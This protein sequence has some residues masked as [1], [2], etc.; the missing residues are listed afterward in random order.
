MAELAQGH[1]DR[2]K[3]RYG[4]QAIPLVLVLDQA[5]II[6]AKDVHDAALDRAIDDVLKEANTEGS[7]AP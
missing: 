7:K 1:D 3:G 4:I 6:R 2:I 5:G